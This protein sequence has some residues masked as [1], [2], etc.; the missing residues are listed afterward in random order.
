MTVTFVVKLVFLDG[1]RESWYTELEGV[2]YIPL[3]GSVL[4][5]SM[6]RCKVTKV[7]TEVFDKDE[8]EPIRVTVHA[9]AKIYEE[10]FYKEAVSMFNLRH[11]E[12][13]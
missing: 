4:R 9:R 7:V 5:V 10:V 12:R 3:I 13:Y 8:S 6:L 2:Q 11:W 1:K